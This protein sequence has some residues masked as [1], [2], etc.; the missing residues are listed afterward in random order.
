MKTTLHSLFIAFAFAAFA[1]YASAARASTDAD[2]ALRPILGQ[3]CSGSLGEVN[4]K[5]RVFAGFKPMLKNGT[6]VLEYRGV[7][8]KSLPDE[9]K[10]PEWK[11]LPLVGALSP[12]INSGD[13][14]VVV[15]SPSALAPR[16]YFFVKE[17]TGGRYLY[18]MQRS[19]MGNAGFTWPCRAVA[20]N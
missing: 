11:Q 18:G 1:I 6:I 10:E 15:T 12:K 2:S 16:F 4:G 17:G 19:K 7:L 8:A 14:S 20:K 13:G 3:V 5:E 9:N